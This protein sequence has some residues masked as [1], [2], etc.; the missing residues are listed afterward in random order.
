[1]K[2]ESIL[3]F[4]RQLRSK[5]YDRIGRLAE[6]T[7]NLT[8]PP[9]V[10]INPKALRPLGLGVIAL[11]RQHGIRITA[12][13]IDVDTLV[14]GSKNILTLDGSAIATRTH[15]TTVDDYTDGLDN[16][17]VGSGSA[18]G[19][20]VTSGSATTNLRYRFSVQ[21]DTSSNSGTNNLRTKRFYYPAFTAN[22]GYSIDSGNI[23]VFVVD[24]I[25]SAQT[26]NLCKSPLSIF[27][28]TV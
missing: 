17:V 7:R 14:I 12:D 16:I 25:T 18:N 20:I 9:E 28:K 23:E 5:A 27:I 10:L 19:S 26:P 13:Q 21:V 24:D 15:R 2:I 11:I 22:T 8:T 4:L 6:N 3:D 1:M